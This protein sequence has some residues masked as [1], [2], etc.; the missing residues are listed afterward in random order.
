M[1]RKHLLT[2]TRH[3]LTWTY[4]PVGGNGGT[5]QNKTASGARCQHPPSGAVG[6]SRSSRHQVENRR[7]A[8]RKLA[9]HPKFKLWLA[10]FQRDASTVEEDLAEKNLRVE[11]WKDG[12]WVEADI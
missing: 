8:L 11:V 12:H 2:I 7:I 9:E 6:E 5:K 4:F 10:G 3:D 1:S